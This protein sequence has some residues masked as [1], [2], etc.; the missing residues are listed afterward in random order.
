MGMALLNLGFGDYFLV[1]GFGLIFPHKS[2][3]GGVVS[4]WSITARGDIMSLCPIPGVFESS[5]E[6]RQ[7]PD[8]SVMCL[9]LCHQERELPGPFIVVIAKFF[10]IKII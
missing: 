9:S 2:V 5:S 10:N 1:T 4:S 6:L 3:T 8:S 7:G